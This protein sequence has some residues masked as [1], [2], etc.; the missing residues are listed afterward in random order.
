MRFL[1]E[2][3]GII[4]RKNPKFEPEGWAHFK[5]HQKQ[6]NTL[7]ERSFFQK[8]PSVLVESTCVCVCDVA[9]ERLMWKVD[10]TST[11]CDPRRYCLFSIEAEMFFLPKKAPEPTI[12]PIYWSKKWVGW[13]LLLLLFLLH[14]SSAPAASLT[15]SRTLPPSPPCVLSRR[16]LAASHQQTSHRRVGGRLPLS[17]SLPL[18]STLETGAT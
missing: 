17:L 9:D 14:L 7:H 11:R 13:C 6:N 3:K 16:L 2:S 1:E 8:T 5:S 15:I 10:N 18:F 12:Y 4:G